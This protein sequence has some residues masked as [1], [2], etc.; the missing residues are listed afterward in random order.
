MDVQLSIALRGKER[1]E[2]D[3]AKE[4]A[5]EKAERLESRVEKEKE[6]NSRGI[7]MDVEDS[8]IQ[9]RTPQKGKEKE[10]ED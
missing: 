9:P 3:F 2:R 8:D 7:A 5:R 4:K 1:E 6:R 10:T